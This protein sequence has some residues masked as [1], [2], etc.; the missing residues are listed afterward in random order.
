MQKNYTNTIRDNAIINAETSATAGDFL[1]A[2]QTIQ[3]TIDELGSDS[4]L[5]VLLAHY[6]EPYAQNVLQQVSV[7][8]SERGYDAVV[9]LLKEAT[10]ILPNNSNLEEEL[11][12]W[13][14][15]HSVPLTDIEY[16]SKSISVG[17]AYWYD[18]TD[19]YGTVY[20]HSITASD[21]GTKYIEYYLG[22]QYAK[23]SGVLYVTSHARSINPSYYTWNIATVSIYGDDHLLYTNVGFTNKDQPIEISIDISEVDFLKIAFENTYYTD[24]G[25]SSSLIGLG[26]PTVGW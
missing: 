21:S 14:S 24:E 19:N 13:N 18:C 4:E 7:I 20:P 5:S 10:S 3:S 15:R 9:A 26:S 12:L 16:F 11:E 23:F 1:S 25:L 22:G 2:F 17:E 8:Y 6:Q